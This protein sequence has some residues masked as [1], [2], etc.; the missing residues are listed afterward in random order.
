M[1]TR[2]THNGGTLVLNVLI[3]H[4]NPIRVGYCG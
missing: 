4:L 1:F 2:S 3:V